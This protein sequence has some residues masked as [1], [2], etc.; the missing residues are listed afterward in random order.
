V[1]IVT[2]GVIV[3]PP[4]SQ[5]ILPGTTRTA[6]E[7]V[8]A[9]AGISYRADPISEQLLRGADEVWISAATREVQPVTQLDGKPVGTGKPGPLW[10]RIYDEWQ[11]YKRELAGQPW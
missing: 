7:E 5:R 1:H 10:R 9:R 11:R 8:A 6:M 4:N 3:S 2:G